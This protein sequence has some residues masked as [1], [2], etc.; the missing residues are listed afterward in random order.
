L[1]TAFS[2]TNRALAMAAHERLG[3]HRDETLSLIIDGLLSTD[4]DDF[5]RQ[6]F[7]NPSPWCVRAA[8]WA[9][10]LYRIGV[11][12][13]H[14]IHTPF[15]TEPTRRRESAPSTLFPTSCETS[16]RAISGFINATI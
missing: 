7:S 4:L 13:N 14:R 3:G 12:G 8:G 11:N 10:P 16:G 15:Y 9:G 2:V 6:F 5:T 1:L